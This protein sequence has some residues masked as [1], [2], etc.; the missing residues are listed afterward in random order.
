VTERTLAAHIAERAAHAGLNVAPEL[1]G[2]LAAYL[3]LLARWNRK[4]NLT[5]FN[6]DE[7]SDDALDRLVVEPVAAARF[8]TA[9]DRLLID[10]GSGGGSP[11]IPLKLAV[12]S[13]R[14]VMVEVKV[15]KSSFLRQAIQELGLEH[16]GVETRRS[17]DVAVDP[18][19]RGAADLVSVRAVRVDSPFLADVAAL[20]R[21]GG[22]LFLFG[23]AAGSLV[24]LGP[25]V[26][27]DR[28]E[29]YAATEGSLVTIAHK[30]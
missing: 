30:P 9:S 16:A 22:R 10:I 28:T 2:R 12:P 26:H 20:L 7:P 13:L 14:L 23:A 4:I 18:S 6:L 15:R 8:I 1:A 29:T 21:P 5:A 3:A 19:F 17:E 27:L 25:Q 24:S 11:A